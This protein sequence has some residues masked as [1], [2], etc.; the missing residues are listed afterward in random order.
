MKNYAIL[1]AAGEGKR[2]K[3]NVPKCAHLLMKKPMAQYV[4]DAVDQEIINEILLVINPSSKDTFS[5]IFGDSVKYVFQEQHLGTGD[6]VRSALGEI[7]DDEGYTLILPCDVPLLDKDEL[8]SFMDIIMGKDADLGVITTFME[9]ASNYGRIVRQDGQIA[10]IQEAFDASDEELSIKEINT[11]IYLVKNAALKHVFNYMSQGKCH[12][13][14]IIEIAKKIGLDVYTYT[15]NN[16]D[17]YSDINDFYTLSKVESKIKIFT[18]RKHLMN[19]VNIISPE[20]VTISSE[21]IIES[22][23]TIYPNTFI[24]GKSIIHTGAV[25]GPDSEVHNSEIFSGAQIRHS[26]ITDSKVGENT[27]VGPFAHLRNHTEVHNNCRIGNFVEIKNSIVA[28]GTKISHLTYL[29]DTDCGKNVNWGCGCVTVNYDGKYKHRTTVGDNV[30][31]GCNTNLIA[32]IKVG[33][34]AFIAA[35]STITED[36]PDEAFSIAR[37]RQVTKEDYARKYPYTSKK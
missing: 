21:V 23:V 8:V 10:R 11:G 28:E 22:G 35:G 2:M 12:L 13:N 34:N 31:I 14:T 17:S 6:A 26:L 15:S 36:I 3:V 18:N 24:T 20:T 33:N 25:V 30:F 27:T 1:L 5:T 9:D 37:T 4:Y 32:P 16:S 19:G 7:K 29:G